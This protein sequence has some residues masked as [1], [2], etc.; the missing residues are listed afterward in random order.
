MLLEK[1]FSPEK[2]AH[3]NSWLNRPIIAGTVSLPSP[4]GCR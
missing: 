1:S 3:F 4:A 2:H